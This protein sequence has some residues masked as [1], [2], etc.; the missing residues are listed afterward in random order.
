MHQKHPLAKKNDLSYSMKAMAIANMMPQNKDRFDVFK[1]L[2]INQSYIRT[3]V[4]DLTLL[5]YGIKHNLWSVG[6]GTEFE[7]I[8]DCSNFSKM[9]YKRT[10]FASTTFHWSIVSSRTLANATI[11]QLLASTIPR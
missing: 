7:N 5:Y 6:L 3:S 10:N 4:F 11:I 1:K 2:F 8:F 9:T